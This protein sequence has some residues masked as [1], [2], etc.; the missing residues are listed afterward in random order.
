MWDRNP[1]G[2]SW[3]FLVRECG[4]VLRIRTLLQTKNC[5]F[6]HSFSDLASKI[7][8]LFQTF[9]WSQNVTSHSVYVKQIYYVIIAEIKTA[10]KCISNLHINNFFLI[11]FELK[12]RTHWYTTVVLRKSYPIPDQNGQNLDPF[13]DQ[14]GVKIKPFGAAHTYMAGIREC[15][16]VL[17][18]DRNSYM[19][20]W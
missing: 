20:E 8:T 2:Y 1:G 15:C 19:A 6:P 17:P 5:H 12:R 7:H 18:R 3:E 9:R 11:H 16:T 10:L 14:N 13:S 4:P